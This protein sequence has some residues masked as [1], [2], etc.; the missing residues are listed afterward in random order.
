MDTS[1]AVTVKV[2]GTSFI[3]GNLLVNTPLRFFKLRRMLNR[4]FK[5]GINETKQEYGMIVSSRKVIKNEWANAEH[6]EGYYGQDIWT[7]YGNIIYPYI[8][9]G[10]TVYGE[11]CGYLTN[12]TKMIQKDYDYGCRVGDNFLMPYRITEHRADGIYDYDIDEVIEFTHRMTDKMKAC[13]DPNFT[14]IFNIEKVLV[15]EGLVRDLPSIDTDNIES[16][17]TALAMQGSLEANEPLCKKKVPREGVVVRINKDQV[18]EAFKLKALKF[19]EREAK[20]VDGGEVDI[21]MANNTEEQ[22]T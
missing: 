6:K 2:H 8:P 21:E 1:I 22:Q 10:I 9:K 14:R 18:S 7:E 3:C 17:T 20:L 5:L 13:S 12:D 11:I 19:M 16:L 15:F 4:F